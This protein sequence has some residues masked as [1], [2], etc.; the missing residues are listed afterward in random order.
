MNMDI[1]SCNGS[2][3]MIVFQIYSTRLYF[4]TYNLY[5]HRYSKKMSK[6]TFIL[7]F[8]WS[9][10]IEQLQI[11]LSHFNERM[12]VWSLKK[13]KCWNRENPD[14][15]VQTIN[16]DVCNPEQLIWPSLTFVFLFNLSNTNPDEIIQIKCLAPKGLNSKLSTSPTNIYI[17]IHIP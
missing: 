13:H 15:N 2:R 6:W 8:N 16:C 7:Y 4:Y 14:L 17:N 12:V 11:F 3:R 9:R 10:W 5:K 1:L